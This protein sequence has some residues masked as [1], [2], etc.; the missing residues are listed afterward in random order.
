MEWTGG[1]RQGWALQAGFGQ[2]SNLPEVTPK[3][4]ED[5][6]LSVLNEPR[7]KF[8]VYWSALGLRKVGTSRSIPVLLNLLTYPMQ[9]VK[10]VAILTI[11]HI[12]GEGVTP[13][14]AEALLSPNYREKGYAM[15]AILDAADERA[16]SAVLQ[17]F[18]K[19]RSKLR[20]GKLDTLGDGIRFLAKFMSSNA[21][22]R[23]FVEAIPAYWNR[24]PKGTRA[25]LNKHL[26]EL[27]AQIEAQSLQYSP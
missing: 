26:P 24:L 1:V 16:I 9:D 22:A 13:L 4:S 12:G 6:L 23:A 27:V 15:W 10:C 5:Y 17:Y 2:G 20:A 8:D 3:T 11:A 19:N 18:S 21:E 25:E 14:L 7:S